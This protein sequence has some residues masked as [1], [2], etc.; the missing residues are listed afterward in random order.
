MQNEIINEFKNGNPDTID[1]FEKEKRRI[2][3]KNIPE[4]LDVST[5]TIILKVN[6]LFNLYNIGNYLPLSDK[7]IIEIKCGDITDKKTNRSLIPKKTRKIKKNKKKDS[8]YNQAT[9]KVKI[10]NEKIINIKIFHN[11]AIQLTGCKSLDNAKESIQ[12]LFPLL[13]KKR[14]LLDF[15]NN[16]IT[17]VV[18]H[19][20]KK[21]LTLNDLYKVKVGLVNTNFNMNFGIDRD[22]LYKK[23][24]EDISIKKFNGKFT[25]DPKYDPNRHACVNIQLFILNPE[26][27]ITVKSVSIF[28][29]EKG[30]IIITGAKNFKQVMSA[31]NFINTYLLSNY[32]NISSND[33][34]INEAIKKTNII[35]FK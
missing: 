20:S 29:F 1:L 22:K 3:I 11:G 16:K 18:Y 30:S 32:F 27:N 15:F 26:L 12:K 25:I 5:M 19:N 14:Y 4:D 34:L 6:T 24:K 17:E 7:D 33:D 2:E 9:L 23:L 21:E 13:N 35:A 8:F 10:D 31:Y 28:V